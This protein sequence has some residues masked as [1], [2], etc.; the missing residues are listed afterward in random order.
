[1]TNTAEVIDIDDLK[2]VEHNGLSSAL[3]GVMSDVRRLQKTDENKHGRYKYVPIDDVKDFVRPLLVK[4]GLT[5]SVSE[6]GKLELS[7]VPNSKG[8]TTTTAVIPYTMRVTHCK[9]GEHSSDT[10]TIVLPYTG[11]QVA[12]IARSY[13]VKEW[14]KATLLMSTGDD[15]A[16]DESNMKPENYGKE[17]E[18]DPD[19]VPKA[20]AR[21]IYDALIQDMN[22]FTNLDKLEMWWLSATIAERRRAL[23]QSWKRT[24]FVEYMAHGIGIAESDAARSGF[25]KSNATALERLTDD[26]LLTI[27]DKANTQREQMAGNAGVQSGAA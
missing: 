3:I 1:M 22:T 5:L 24:L 21:S 27:D 4:H 7:E 14:A 25:K 18:F 10:I 11:A 26:E 12:G 13:A 8:G 19:A 17:R 2:S 15:V 6:A 23:P 20:Q 9:S 16:D